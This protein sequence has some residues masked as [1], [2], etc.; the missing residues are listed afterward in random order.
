MARDPSL[1]LDALRTLDAIDRRGSFAA[2]AEELAKVPSALSYNIQKLEDD[3]GLLL[4]DRTGHRAKLTPVGRLVLE[5]GR[6]ILGATGQMI[7]DARA[8]SDGWE[9][10]LTIGVEQ[11][12]HESQLLPLIDEFSSLAD[13]RI[14]L[15]ATVLSGTW[16]MLEMG[17]ADLVIGSDIGLAGADIQMRPLTTIYL[18]YYAAAAHPIFSEKQPLH[19]NTLGKY[20][21]VAVADTAVQ[22][23][24]RDANI[25]D[26]QPR[27]TV[28]DHK[29]KLSAIRAGLAVGTL[30]T[31]LAAPD[32]EA[33]ALKAIPGGEPIAVPLVLAW[34]NEHLGRAKQW[35]M[36]RISETFSRMD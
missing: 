21:A 11:L 23:P 9:P 34:K 28:S 17:L 3:L 25:L 26:K 1:T 16:E 20:R 24:K 8:L 33:G 19:P 13:T 14:K 32:L 22:R 18:S 2:A 29:T 27:L 31:Q 15:Q 35:F 7:A 36:Q 10:E 5:R 4:F 6:E 30:P 12:I